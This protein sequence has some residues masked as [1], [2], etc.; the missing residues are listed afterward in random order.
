M[1]WTDFFFTAELDYDPQLLIGKKMTAEESLAALARARE[2]LASLPAFDE[3][4]LEPALR[5]RA[6]EM[7][8]KAGQLFGVIRVAVTGKKVAPPLFGTLTVLGR[9]KTLQRLD[10]ALKMLRGM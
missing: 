4:A 1:E 5:A 9:E 8:L 7:G 6:E 2:T 3:E 10:K